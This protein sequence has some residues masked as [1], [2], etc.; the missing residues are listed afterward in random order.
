SA[1]N[2]LTDISQGMYRLRKLN[3]GHHVDFY[4]TTDIIKYI[5][6][7]KFNKPYL[8]YRYLKEKDELSLKQTMIRHTLQ[9]IKTNN[10]LLNYNNPNIND[11]YIETLYDP[12]EY[13]TKVEYLFLSEADIYAQFII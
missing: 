5:N 7:K 12:L 3:Y 2:N 9:N 11:F 6:N 8:L 4:V 10:R 13:V 1:I